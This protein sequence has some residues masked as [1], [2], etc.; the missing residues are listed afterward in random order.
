MK[1]RIPLHTQVLIGLAL[2]ILLGGFGGADLMLGPIRATDIY[3]FV[4]TLFLRALGMIVVPLVATSIMSSIADIGNGKDVGRLG[5]KTAL[6]YATTSFFAILVGLVLVNTIQPGIIDGQPA[7]QVLNLDAKTDD[8]LRA[9]EDRD[10]GDIAEVF[11]RM[12]P[13]NVFDS[14]SRG[15]LLGLIFFSIVFGFFMSRVT[16]PPGEQ[17]RQTVRGI[18]D[19]MLKVTQWILYFAPIGVF[20]LVAARIAETGFDVFRPLAVYFFTVVAAL[21]V[22]FLVVLPLLL[23]LFA[24]VNPTRHY[25]A[26]WPAILTAFSTAS[27]AATLPVTMDCVQKRA[28]VSKRT[29]SFVLP[30]GATINMDGTALYE[31]VVAMFIAQAYGI[32]LSFGQQFMVVMLALLTSIG[33]AGVPQA[34]LVAIVII[35]NAV[36]L[37]PE[38]IGLVLAVD[39][40]LDMMRTAVNIFSDSCGAV[41]VGRWEGEKGILQSPE[42]DSE[43]SAPGA[44]SQE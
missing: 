7:S 9:T 31:C 15:D 36:G 32:E 29:T 38:G 30:M 12:V 39:R 19:T 40:I 33:V 14:A 26:M 25:V 35:L 11:L 8:A 17:V 2:A 34:S 20:G 10:L 4:G 5:W 43:R 6:Y 1:L 37:P 22:H 44:A 23:L 13:N 42:K 21:G 24:R 18:Y 3:E 27:S 41:V 16:G 28:G